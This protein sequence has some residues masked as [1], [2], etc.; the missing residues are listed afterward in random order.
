VAV[1]RIFHVVLAG[2][3]PGAALLL[4][5]IVMVSAGVGVARQ[6]ALNGL[7]SATSLRPRRLTKRQQ[8]IDAQQSHSYVVHQHTATKPFVGSGLRVYRWLPPL[9]IQLLR[10]GDGDREP[11][12]YLTAPFR[13]H[14]LVDHVKRAMLRVGDPDDPARLLGFQ[15][16]D[17][18]YVDEMNLTSDRDCLRTEPRRSDIV[19]I[20]DTPHGTTH[21]NLEIRVNGQRQLVVTIFLRVIII[22]RSLSV[23]F[24]A[25]ALTGTPVEYQLFNLVEESGPGAVLR[26]T[27]RELRSIPDSLISLW[28]LAEV[29]LVLASAMWARTDRSLVPRRRV[30]IG[31]RPS[32]REVNSLPWDKAQLDKESVY[33]TIKIMEQRILGSVEDFLRSHGVDTSLFEKRVASIINSGVINFGDMEISKT[34]IGENAQGQFGSGGAGD[35]TGAAGGEE[36]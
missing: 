5:L 30:M 33:R 34:V 25:C 4:L 24:S 1:A 27:L 6:L 35:A 9:V 17:R 12:E 8:V 31:S 23:D 3:V 13:P 16:R 36:S 28:R 20:I 21:H 26:S 14:D 15:I 11:R 29:P 18:L 19:R 32:I 2:A 10:P 22:G 7:R